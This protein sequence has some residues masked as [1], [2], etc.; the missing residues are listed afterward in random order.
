M[1][2]YWYLSCLISIFCLFSISAFG[3]TWT[4]GSTTI[5]TSG[6]TL[7]VSG[8]G[9][10]ADYGYSD[11]T[12]WIS[13]DITSI[14]I[15][16][17][18]THIGAYAFIDAGY[19][20]RVD[21]PVSVTS[22]GEGAFASCF[23]IASIYYAGSP[24]EWASITFVNDASNP[25]CDSSAGTRKFY[26]HGCDFTTT[27]LVLAPGI[28]RI[29]DYAFYK[30]TIQH[31][32]IPG[33]VE[34]IGNFAF[35]CA[36][37]NSVC[38][39]RAT[40]PAT[41]AYSPITYGSSA[42]LYVPTSAVS[43]YNAVGTPW[44]GT[45]TAKGPGATGQT[46][47]GTLSSTYGSGVKWSLEEDGILTLDASGSTASKTVTL[48]AGTDYPWGN[49]RR[50]VDK[51][52]LKGEIT[53]LGNALA[54]HWFLSGIILDQ[55]TVPTC[56]NY[57]GST[58]LTSAASYSSL[59]N[60]CHPLTLRIKLST[61]LNST[62]RAKLETAPW[63]DGHWQVAIDDEVIIDENQDNI[64][65]LETIK[66]YTS[67]PFNMRLERT[68]TNAYF[69]TF[70]SPVSLSA[71]EVEAT[72]G[73]GTLIHAFTGTSYDEAANELTLNFDNAQDYIEAGVP[74]LFKPANTVSNPLFT[75]VD[76]ADVV[77]TEGSVNAT[78]AS[79]Y[80]TLAPVDVTSAQVNAQ[81]FIFLQA[82]N[83][84]TWANGGTLKGM[85]AYWLLSPGVP[86]H[87]LARRPV[88]RIGNT[89]TGID[90][91][92]REQVPSTKV[93]RNG[94]LLIIRDGKTYNAQGN[95]VK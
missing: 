67:A 94:Q 75:D 54:Y 89:A 55:N 71:D 62:E 17:G 10:M 93:I 88:M 15:E 32:N 60:P 57:I 50:L 77:D 11:D 13:D 22:I 95:L 91:V 45:T 5:T 21:V 9:A 53:A 74:Y 8:N 63:N 18:V 82:N 47:S 35:A 27:T 19:V 69:N 80:G 41:G 33:S 83:S 70:C 64:A 87:V 49:F 28:K 73:T 44:K 72:F 46:L 4:S 40:P 25:F 58:N 68:L 52:K 14:I 84:L 59:F 30:A 85:R 79:F 65:L 48:K 24:N 61:L 51:V 12:P 38:I 78:H 37:S 31:L 7:T 39:N 42:K 6:A 3:G 86:S 1:K 2:R 81:S 36:V 26:F 56:S 23:K 90:Q 92:I 20:T 16:D 29:N 76:P 34:Y 43:T 66:D